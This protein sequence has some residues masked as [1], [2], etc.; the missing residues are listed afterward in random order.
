MRLSMRGYPRF[1][2]PTDAWR[3]SRR[4][5]TNQSFGCLFGL[6]ASILS[7]SFSVC[8]AS[9]LFSVY[10]AMICRQKQAVPKRSPPVHERRD[11]LTV[12]ELDSDL[13]LFRMLPYRKSL[14]S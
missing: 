11:V 10:R 3:C 13:R 2:P 8:R 9:A 1:A 14:G 7:T 6:Q 5:R 4:L 12:L